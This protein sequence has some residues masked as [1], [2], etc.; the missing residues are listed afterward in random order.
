MA[1]FIKALLLFLLIPTVAFPQSALMLAVVTLDDATKQV[2][3]DSQKKILG[4][5]TESIDGREVHVIKVLTP[6]GRIQHL[7]IDAET[8]RLLGRD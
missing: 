8:G 2:R 6:D 7:K 4:A 5:K 1:N 3:Q